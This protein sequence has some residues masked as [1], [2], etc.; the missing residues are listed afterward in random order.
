MFTKASDKKTAY[1]FFMNIAAAIGG[2]GSGSGGRASWPLTRRFLAQTSLL[3]FPGNN[4]GSVSSGR[5]TSSKSVRTQLRLLSCGDFMVGGVE[6]TISCHKE[7]LRIKQSGEGFH[8]FF[9]VDCIWSSE[10]WQL[11]DWLCLWK[12]REA[13]DDGWL[14]F[15]VQCTTSRSEATRKYQS[16]DASSRSSFLLT[17]T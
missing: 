17:S 12:G 2:V 8:S 10:T 13:S 1:N 14:V 6:R 15:D 9:L 16:P 11:I 5:A 3:S 4:P 7:P